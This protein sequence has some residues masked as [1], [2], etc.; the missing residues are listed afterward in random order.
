MGKDVHFVIE[1]LFLIAAILVNARLLWLRSKREKNKELSLF[2]T[3]LNNRL[4]PNRSGEQQT[5]NVQIAVCRRQE[6]G[7]FSRAA[8]APIQEAA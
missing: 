5:Y 3:F 7:L 1:L 6:R 2:R 4:L 8:P